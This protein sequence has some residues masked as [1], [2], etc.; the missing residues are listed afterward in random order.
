MQRRNLMPNGHPEP[1]LRAH[2]PLLALCIGG[3]VLEATLIGLLGPRSALALAPQGTAMAPYGVFHD[4]RWLLVYSHSWLTVGLESVAFLLVRGLMTAITVRLAWPHDAGQPPFAVLLRRSIAFTAAAAVLLVFSSSLL[5]GLAVASISY[6]FFAA[7]PVALFFA[8]LIHQGPVVSW[9]RARPTL[10]TLGW[11]ALSFAILTLGGATMAASPW[12][13][14]IFFAALVGLFNAWA[15]LG[16]VRALSTRPSRGFVPIAPVGIAAVVA[17]VL[18]G[19]LISVQ[20]ETASRR[21]ANASPPAGARPGTGQ[22]VLV[23]TGYDSH[24]HGGDELDFGPGFL[25]RRFSYAGL[26]G[27]G[28]PLVFHG[29]DTDRALP[30]LVH[31]LDTQTRTFAA[32]TG[33]PVDIVSDSEGALVAKVFL[34]VHPD[35]PVRSLVLTS[36]LV[37]PG[38][39]Y[40]PTRGASGYGIAAGWGLRGVSAA[41]R[42]LTPLDLSP[43]GPFLRSIANHGPSLRDALGCPLPNTAQLALFPLADAVG[44][45]YDATSNIA[46]AVLPAFHGKLLERRSAQ[47]AIGAYLRS[48]KVPGY[49]GLRLTE[50]LVRAGAAA[51]QAP[52]LRINLNHGGNSLSASGVIG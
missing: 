21:I 10:R 18:V 34:L 20:L 39:D 44:A 51:W 23:I 6:L 49:G 37:S 12:P 28:H 26:D 46:A 40:F 29:P 35:A 52:S 42:A 1:S 25:Q 19:V 17:V 2:R 16:T 3:A 36:P 7:V 38:R 43:D 41:L 33:Q 27:T 30:Q 31:Q 50:R 14:G 9:W 8:L 32:Q 47:H 15:W 24:W 22:P 13:A 11:A 45:P 5:V 48:G 4:L